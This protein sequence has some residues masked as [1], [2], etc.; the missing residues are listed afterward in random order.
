VERIIRFSPLN[1][2]IIY[3][4]E[5]E[6]KSRGVTAF[7]KGSSLRRYHK[8]PPEDPHLFLVAAQIFSL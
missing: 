3:T 4:V 6:T 8:D 5:E 7:L 2:L 1:L